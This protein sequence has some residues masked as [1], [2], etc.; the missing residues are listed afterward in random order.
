MQIHS[1]F[2]TK[3]N[4]R[5]SLIELKQKK[6]KSSFRRTF[7]RLFHRL[8]SHGRAKYLQERRLCFLDQVLLLLVVV[9]CCSSSSSSGLCDVWFSN[10]MTESGLSY[11]LMW[12][13]LNNSNK[14]PMGK[15]SASNFQDCNDGSEQGVKLC[16]QPAVL[17]Q[18]TACVEMCIIKVPSIKRTCIGVT[19]AL[20]CLLGSP[21][22][23]TF[24]S[25]SRRLLFHVFSDKKLN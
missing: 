3:Y 4:T 14:N 18:K 11:L 7:L 23:F 17:S 19:G 21:A 13:S 12:S 10:E 6:T 2:A 24:D 20:C 25:R 5:A 8:Y 15:F 16:I 1:K 9:T 22:F